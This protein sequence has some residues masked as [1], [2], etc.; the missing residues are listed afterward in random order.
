MICGTDIQRRSRG[1][2]RVGGWTRRMK[3]EGR[4][5]EE[6]G[7]RKKNVEEEEERGGGSKGKFSFLTFELVTP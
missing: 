7:G 2:L 5:M 4:K 1:K 6:G 3:R